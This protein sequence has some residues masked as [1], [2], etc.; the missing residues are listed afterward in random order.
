MNVTEKQKQILINFMR[1]NP[2]FG[3]GQLRYNRENKKQIEKLWEKV[4]SALNS[5]GCGPQK[6]SKEWAK[7]WRDWKSNLL[8]R[9]ATYKSYAARTG[10]GQPIILNTSPAEDD[11]LEFLT[12][13]ASG[14]SNIPEGGAISDVSITDLTIERVLTPQK[15]QN[16]STSYLPICTDLTA[17]RVSSQ[18]LE[19]PSTLQI[20][21]FSISPNLHTEKSIRQATSCFQGLEEHSFHSNVTNNDTEN[22]PISISSNVLRS[23]ENEQEQIPKQVHCIKSGSISI[24]SIKRHSDDADTSNKKIKK[25][26][27]EHTTDY[28]NLQ[29]QI[30]QLKQEKLAILKERLQLKKKDH[31]DYIRF[32]KSFL[33]KMDELMNIVRSIG[34]QYLED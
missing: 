8:R 13:E 21:N 3:R 20:T 24:K 29:E 28:C 7:T 18:K 12:S 22:F 33:E 1:A 9:V 5:A 34:P 25:Q 2:D 6:Q 31:E 23:I 17:E 10:G 19:N 32:F 4:T 11:L 27:V 26:N 16:P 30:L 15:W 14:M